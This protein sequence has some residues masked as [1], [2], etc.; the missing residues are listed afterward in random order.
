MVQV[1]VITP[2]RNGRAFLGEAIASV[3]AQT[4][5]DWE[6]LIV[7]DGSTDSDGT[8][9][10]RPNTSVKT[11]A[12][13]SGWRIAHSPP[14]RVCWYQTFRSRQIRKR[15]SSA[16]RRSSRR[17]NARQPRVGKITVSSSSQDRSWAVCNI[18]P[19]HLMLSQA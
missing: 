6:M 19:P 12:P 8:R 14:S 5:Q 11:A 9:A 2:V 4:A 15:R 17:S 18:Q 1:S 3:Q 13:A 16:R 10:R 7:D